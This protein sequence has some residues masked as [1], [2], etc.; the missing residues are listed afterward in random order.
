LW[1]LNFCYFFQK[2]Y[3]F[4]HDPFTFYYGANG[5]W[6]GL[7]LNVSAGVIFLWQ[8]FAKKLNIKRLATTSL[9]HEKVLKIFLLSY[10]NIAE[11]EYPG[12]FF[13]VYLQGTL[14]RIIQQ[15]AFQEA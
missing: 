13:L 7:G 9:Q 2:F 12:E 4:F 6:G 11:F 8:I 14:K 15:Q 1:F 5:F 10:L 3:N